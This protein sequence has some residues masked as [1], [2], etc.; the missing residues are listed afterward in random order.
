MV[1]NPRTQVW[2]RMLTQRFHRKSRGLVVAALVV[3]AM[4]AGSAAATRLWSNR[5]VQPATAQAHAPVVAPIQSGG[6]TRTAEALP[7]QLRSGGFVP[8][9]LSRPKGDYYF[10][11]QD[12]SGSPDTLLQLEVEHGSRIRQANLKKEKR[13]WRELVHLPPGIYLLREA[14]HPSW[15]C[16]IA[17][18]AQ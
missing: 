2:G 17:I 3:P 9:E 1:V 8:A 13:V 4:I 7:I 15:I 11:V 6:A 18:T 10:S 16:R 5:H 14:N 12:V